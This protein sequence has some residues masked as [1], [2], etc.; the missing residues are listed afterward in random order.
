MEDDDRHCSYCVHYEP[1]A[2]FRMYCKALKR[3]ITA[4]KKPCKYYESLINKEKYE[5]S[6]SK[7]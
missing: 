2:D 6:K 1:C 3:R 7:N 4:N 5:T